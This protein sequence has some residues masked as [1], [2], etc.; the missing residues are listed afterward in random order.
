MLT[1][2]SRWSDSKAH[3]KN[4]TRQTHNMKSLP[5]SDAWSTKSTNHLRVEL[6]RFENDTGVSFANL[7]EPMAN[8]FISLSLFQIL[9]VRSSNHTQSPCDSEKNI[10]FQVAA[11]WRR[12]VS[13]LAGHN[14][15]A[16]LGHGGCSAGLGLL[17]LEQHLHGARIC[18]VSVRLL[19][20]ELQ[21]LKLLLL[22]LD[23][24]LQLLLCL[25]Q[26]QQIASGVPE[27]CKKNLLQCC[28]RPASQPR[29]WFTSHDWQHGRS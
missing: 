16:R 23:R 17:P 4:L 24:P 27:R 5:S 21:P 2:S 3:R 11:T 18:G 19:V 15:A 8:Y 6:C 13:A 26:Y 7:S 25:V 14:V 22:A 28:R 29:D 12:Q 1:P 10:S 20:G 9:I